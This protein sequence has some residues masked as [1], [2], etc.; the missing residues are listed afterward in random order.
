MPYGYHGKI[1]H[2][3]LDDLTLD[4]ETPSEA[5]YQTYFG[6]SALGLYYLLKHTPAEADPLGPENTLVLAISPLTG[7]PISGQSRM[8][9]VAKSPLT[10][11]VGDAQCGGFFPAELKFSGYDAI[12]I[13]G[14]ADKPVY[15]WINNGKAELRPAEHLWGKTTGEVDDL[16][17]EEL[18]DDKVQ[19][20][21]TG[22]AGEKGVLFS[23][24]IN[25]ANRANGRTGMGAVMGSKNLKAIAVRGKQR[26]A[27]ADPKGLNELA[28]WGAKEFPDSDVY[29]LGLLGTAEVLGFQNKSGGLP[30]RNWFSGSFEGWKPIDGKTMEKTILKKRDTCYACTVRCKRVVEI[31]EGPYIVDPRYGGPE[32]ETL[33][34]FGSYCGIDDLEAISYANQL[35]NMYGM[36]TI[37]CGATIAWA[38][39]CFEQGLITTEDTGG[40]AL[41]FGDAAA[42]VKMV[43]AI[44]KRQGFGDVLAEGSARAADRIGRGT[45][46]LVVAV[47]KQ[48]MPAHMPQVKR[49]VGLIYAVNPFGAD[50]QSHEHDPSYAD[51][52]ERMAEIGLTN[53]QPDDV[54]NEEKV[55]YALITEYLY[56][57]LDTVNM[58]QFVFGPAWQLYSAGNLAEAMR[59][60]TGQDFSIDDVLRIG[61]RRLN[62]LRAFNARESIGREADKL[63][64]KMYQ[65]LTGGASDGV[66]LT[67]K[68]IED[69]KDIYYQMA[70]W[71]VASGTPTRAKLEELELG[72]VAD[73][74]EV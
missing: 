33:A 50:H 54:L 10:D 25:M 4:V 62:L 44:A 59:H 13:H 64:K 12:V 65:A 45:Q 74:L 21:Q 8:T 49:S 11:A 9:S 36:D 37:S 57:A 5:F 34:T 46:D 53:P 56:S 58:C 60:V 6:G 38:M 70:G 72:W 55:R 71:D 1:L 3:H 48:E 69:A 41:R 35:C 42:M 14:R 29:G 52:P 40:I 16:L 20:L 23:A 18:G 39:D 66:A 24:L 68:E 67:E 63:P 2:L 47:K 51:Y 73:L 32:Y 61:E 19:V 15:L 27:L 28:R 31:T 22:L 30:T 7:A 26:P 43:E 17:K